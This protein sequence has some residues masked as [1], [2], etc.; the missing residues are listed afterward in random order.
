[1]NAQFPNGLLILVFVFQIIFQALRDGFKYKYDRYKQIQ[2]LYLVH[3]FNAIQ[4]L[5]LLSLPFVVK[6]SNDYSILVAFSLYILSYALFRF[7]IFDVIYN[8]STNHNPMYIG[9]SSYYDRI[10][11]KIF[12]TPF[13]KSV[14]MALRVI[15]II[16]GLYILQYILY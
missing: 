10:L 13:L 12:A 6:F 7:G 2:S 4:V 15:S 9:E 5:L 8:L 1:M 14:L 16:G 11:S 3:I